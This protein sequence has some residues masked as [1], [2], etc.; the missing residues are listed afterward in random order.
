MTKNT[1]WSIDNAHSCAGFEIQH[2]AI[3]KING[4]FNT[5]S[6]KLEFDEA[7]SSP[8]SLEISIDPASINTGVDKRDEH[9][10]SPD[11]FDTGKYPEIT[12][13]SEKIVPGRD[14]SFEIEGSLSL[15][16]VSKI[17]TITLAGLG[18]EEK[19]PWG[20]TRR[21]A[22]IT[23]RINRKDF[24]MAYNSV[25]ESGNL[26]IG[27]AVDLNIAIEFVRS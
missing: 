3:S 10:R 13:V 21:G 9:L 11:F 5:I 22:H 25:L 15:H 8:L 26:L 18:R 19:D 2:M 7:A 23:G 24:G 17:I 14:G 6:G 12:F 1:S 27:E 20:N 4:S 16:G